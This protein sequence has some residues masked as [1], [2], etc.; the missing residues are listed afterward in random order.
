MID[1]FREEDDSAVPQENQAYLSKTVQLRANRPKPINRYTGRSIV[2]R[3][4]NDF[5]KSVNTILNKNKVAREIAER[6]KH[7]PWNRLKSW[8][9]W[10]KQGVTKLWKR[11]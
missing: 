6:A 3:N 2:M 1:F 4:P 10:I 11:K 7:Y 8:W 9:A 5:T